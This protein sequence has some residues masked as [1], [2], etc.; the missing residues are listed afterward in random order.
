LSDDDRLRAD[1]IQ[2]LM[3]Q[4]EI[5]VAAL[6]RRYAIDF[7]KHFRDS[8]A[9][10]EP[11]IEDGLVRIDVDRIGVT[12]QGRFFLRNIAMCFDAYID[13]AAQPGRFSRAL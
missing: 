9:R 8:L 13:P 12:S 4:S 11:M 5:P 10:L 6:E 2:C 3:C 1:V 7:D